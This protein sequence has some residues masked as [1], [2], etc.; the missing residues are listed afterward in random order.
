MKRAVEKRVITIMSALDP[1]RGVDG[2]DPSPMKRRAIKKSSVL[3]K[4]FFKRLIDFT[5]SVLAVVLLSPAIVVIAA[6]IKIDSS[7]PIVIRQECTGLGGRRFFLFKFRTI[8]CVELRANESSPKE[9]RDSLTNVGRCLEASHL[10]Q[11]PHMIN[12]LLG[13]M[14]FVGP[15]PYGLREDRAFAQM[16]EG[17][18]DRFLVRPGLIGPDRRRGLDFENNIPLNL[19]KCLDSDIEYIESWTINSDLNRIADSFLNYVKFS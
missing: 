3:A 14:S 15:K 16:I 9:K 10:D 4:C 19:R 17:Y 11:L 5:I 2:A 13:D 1:R 6:A 12:I 8:R 18:N 7:G